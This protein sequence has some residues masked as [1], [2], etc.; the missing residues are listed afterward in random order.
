M[1]E[2]HRVELERLKVQ[3]SLIEKKLQTQESAHLIAIQHE[4]QKVILALTCITC[5][6]LLFCQISCSNLQSGTSLS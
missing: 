3:T 2:K 5:I 1:E 6:T 4:I